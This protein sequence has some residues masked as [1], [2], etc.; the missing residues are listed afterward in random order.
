MLIIVENLPVPFDRRVWHE[1]TT[2]RRAGYEVSV[3]CPMGKG[4]DRPYEVIEDVHV[5]RHPMPA[6]ARGVLGYLREYAAALFWEFRLSRRV[7]RERGFDIVHICNPPD[8]LF[9][10]A[11]WHKV[12]GRAK[13]VFDHHDVNPELYEEKFG[14][15]GVFYHLLLVCEYLTMRTADVVISTNE[16][17]RRVALTRGRKRSEDVF[18]VRSA[19]DVQRF[20]RV[21]PD[22]DLRRG[23]TY[24]VGYLGVMAEQDGV[25][26]LL[27]VAREIVYEVGRTD[28]GFLLVGGGP[29]LEALV[30]LR[31]RLGLQDYVEF[32]GFQTGEEL[33]RRLSTF[34]VGVAPDP[35]T[36][37][38]R[39]CTMNKTIEYM[40]LGLPVVQFDL[41][42]GRA[43][44]GDASLYVEQDDPKSMADAILR[45]LDDAELR[46]ALGQR[47]RERVETRLAWH[48]QAPHLLAAYE[49]VLS[50]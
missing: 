30:A 3:I 1:A 10:V 4:Y 16:S 15:R 49:R 6:E 40:A 42:E 24:L 37:Y 23:R 44:A 12:V 22:P 14:R 26:T 50:R 33:L 20:R 47:G 36:T 43:S 17:Y 2:L 34:D 18:V 8:L 5:Y 35:N 32:A 21:A 46:Q 45:L 11:G 48:H 39:M 29:S 28:V 41:T 25:D 31:D 19:P 13:V 27:H 7:R 9:L 38:N